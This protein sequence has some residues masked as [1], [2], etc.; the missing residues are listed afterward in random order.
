MSNEEPAAFIYAKVVPG[1]LH[2]RPSGRFVGSNGEGGIL[3][4]T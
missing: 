1:Y 2:W 3:I 4:G